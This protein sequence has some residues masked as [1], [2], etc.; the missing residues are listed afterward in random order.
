MESTRSH[1]PADKSASAARKFGKAAPQDPIHACTQ[2]PNALCP[3]G[4]FDGQ[5]GA[6][7]ARDGDLR[8]IDSTFADNGSSGP[9]H[10]SVTNAVILDV[11]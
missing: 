9:S 3:T 2:T 5:G 4:F 8:I 11:R 6:L 7:Y 10:F 1:R